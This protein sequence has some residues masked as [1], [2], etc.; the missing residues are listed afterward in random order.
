MSHEVRYAL[1]N[2]VTETRD[3]GYA[4]VRQLFRDPSAV[5]DGQV[6]A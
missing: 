1:V 5:E 3:D 6:R 2:L 4:C